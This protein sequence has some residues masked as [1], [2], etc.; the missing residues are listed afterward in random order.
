[1]RAMEQTHAKTSFPKEPYCTAFTN[2]SIYRKPEAVE[3]ATDIDKSH[4]LF[5]PEGHKKGHVDE[6]VLV[7][8]LQAATLD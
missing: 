8:K 4:D 6:E 1:M 3:I 2:T 5:L 7:R